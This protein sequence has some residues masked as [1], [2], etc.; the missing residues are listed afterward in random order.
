M[1]INKR[2][3]EKIN[4]NVEKSKIIDWLAL[5]FAYYM[6]F[7][8]AGI[9]LAFLFIDFNRYWE[10]VWKAFAA[11]FLARGIAQIIYWFFPRK[12]PFVDNDDVK[13]ILKPKPTPSFP[14]GHAISFFA[15]SMVIYYFNPLLGKI[16]FLISALMGIARVYGGVHWPMDVIVGAIIGV[17][18]GWQFWP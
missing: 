3:F 18:V 10:M 1:S 5:F 14:S 2:L 12:R 15:F 17:L 6:G 9:V 11:A 7:I 13:L 16:F 4:N 8:M